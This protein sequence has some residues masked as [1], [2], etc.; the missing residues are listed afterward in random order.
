MSS[1]SSHAVLPRM[2]SEGAVRRQLRRAPD[3]V[4]THTSGNGAPAAVGR[5]QT[6]LRVAQD[7]IQSAIKR[8]YPPTSR[9]QRGAKVVRTRDRGRK[10][11]N[12]LD[13]AGGTAPRRGQNDMSPRAVADQNDPGVGAVAPQH[14]HPRGDVPG[15][16]VMPLLVELVVYGVLEPAPGDG[17]HEEGQTL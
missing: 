15:R 4:K 11:D 3:R 5:A 8:V 9:H 7:V 16:G 1:L 10:Q 13:A 14:L 12:A 17:L 6:L 2:L